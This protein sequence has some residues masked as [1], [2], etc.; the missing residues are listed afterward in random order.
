M[1][2]VYINPTTTTSSSLAIYLGTSHPD[3]T[4]ALPGNPTWR[5][6]GRFYNNNAG[7]IDQY[8]ITH[9]T[10]RNAWEYVVTEWEDHTPTGEHTTN[11]TYDGSWR[12]VGDS[13]EVLE[14]VTYTGTSN[15]AVGNPTHDIPLG[16]RASVLIP[17]TGFVLPGGPS[18]FED[19][20]AGFGAT[21]VR[22]PHR[23]PCL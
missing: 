8:S 6:L 9:W 10:D 19:F 20:S 12:R 11:T 16:L 15:T 18:S 1:Y 2:Y 23:F 21:I 22:V 17:L 13:I 4:G 5:A 3:S 7:D 14:Y